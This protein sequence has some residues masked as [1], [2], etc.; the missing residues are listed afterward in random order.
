MTWLDFVL[1][2]LLLVSL[3]MGARLGSLWISACLAAGF[4][5]ALLVDVYALSFGTM[6]GSFPGAAPLAAVLLFVGG[7]IAFLIPGWIL[8][9]VCEGIFLGVIDSAFGL[10]AGSVAG[11][12]AITL[13]LLVLVPMFPRVE[14]TSAWRNSMLVRPLQHSLEE[15]LS[16]PHFR[17][18]STLMPVAK[19]ASSEI[20]EVTS[21]I[22]NEIKKH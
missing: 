17:R 8:S 14:R 10:L 19:E 4:F 13:I 5:G 16:K 2:A 6:L 20:K 18:P 11:L 12:S 3:G 21:K 22:A 9:R 1:I 7:C 15:V